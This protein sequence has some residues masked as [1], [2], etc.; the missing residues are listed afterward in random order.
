[1]P[2]NMLISAELK[3]PRNFLRIR[4]GI[5]EFKPESTLKL[6]QTKPQIS[7]T[8]PTNRHTT[9]P[10]DSGPI[11]ACFDDVPKL[12]KLGDSSAA[13]MVLIVANGRDRTGLR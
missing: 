1:M 8:V 9:I 2:E 5:F 11:P 6:G 10:T 7:R 13:V 12:F 4:P 3:G